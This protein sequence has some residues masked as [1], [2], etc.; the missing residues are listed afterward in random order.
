MVIERR[1]IGDGGLGIEAKVFGLAP[2]LARTHRHTRSEENPHHLP[3]LTPNPTIQ[4]RGNNMLR[5]FVFLGQRERERER[6]V[7]GG[8]GNGG[9]I[10]GQGSWVGK[11]GFW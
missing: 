3:H 2:L 7:V 11:R 10:R 4:F 5:S 6:A 8:V 1:G 9:W